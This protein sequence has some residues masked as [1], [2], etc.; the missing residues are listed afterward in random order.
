MSAYFTID[1]NNSGGSFAEPAALLIVE[2]SEYD[3]AIRLAGLHIEFCGDSGLYADYDDCGC[4]PCCGHRW[5]KP[6]R[7][8]ETGAEI[9]ECGRLADP[10]YM[11]VASVALIRSDGTIMV[12]DTPEKFEA[13]KAEV[14]A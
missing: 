7:D 8:R 11:G 12:S 4:C 9:I 1:Q 10:R 5:D 13:I 14:G 3:E 6:E 2:A